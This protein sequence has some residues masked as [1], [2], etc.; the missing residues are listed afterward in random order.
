MSK[1]IQ[2]L[3][4]SRNQFRCRFNNTAVVWKHF[5]LLRQLLIVSVL[6]PV[7]FLSSCS[8]N[9]RGITISGNVTLDGTPIPNGQIHFLDQQTK[10]P[11]TAAIRNGKYS[12]SIEPG[13]KSVKVFA[14][15]IV[16]KIP[17]DS[18]RPDGEM[19]DKTEQYV[20]KQFNTNSEL[21]ITVVNKK[22]VH[23]FNLKTSEP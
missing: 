18:A 17:R 10:V 7:L 13:E 5:N 15:K 4:L 8:S 12:V 1:K 22:E 16:G 19:I 9:E 11:V 23:D 20:P 2:K 3:V 14:E 21:K 6:L